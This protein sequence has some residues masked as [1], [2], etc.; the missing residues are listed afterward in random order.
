MSFTRVLGLLVFLIAWQIFLKYSCH[1]LAAIWFVFL[2]YN[3]QLCLSHFGRLLW[4]HH[5]TESSASDRGEKCKSNN[6]TNDQSQVKAGTKGNQM[7]MRHKQQ[8]VPLS[9]LQKT[10]FPH[11]GMHWHNLCQFQHRGFKYLLT[12]SNTVRLISWIP[13]FED[14]SGNQSFICNAAGCLCKAHPRT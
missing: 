2:V 4:Q 10:E 14:K 9:L 1:T 7:M 12:E 6:F 11:Y 13:L 8:A 5:N 3:Q